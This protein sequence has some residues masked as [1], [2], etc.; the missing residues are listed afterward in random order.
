MGLYELAL[1]H[2]EK[3]V[4]LDPD[5]LRLRRNLDFCQEKVRAA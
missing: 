4:G 2:A 3:A 5:D 1:E